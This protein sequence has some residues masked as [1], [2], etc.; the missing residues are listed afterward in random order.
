MANPY[1]F[2]ARALQR[3]KGQSAVATAAYQAGE[4]LRDQRTG[5]GH[6]YSKKKQGVMWSEIL[7]PSDSPGWVKDRGYLWNQA[8]KAEKRKDGQSARRIILALPKELTHELRREYSKQY[9]QEQFVNRGMVADFSIHLPEPGKN[10]DN[11]HLHLLTTMRD[12]GPDGFGSK[13]RGWNQKSLLEEWREQ[14]AVHTNRALTAAGFT[15]HWDHRTLEAQGVDRLPGVHLGPNVVEMEQKGLSTDRA[16]RALEIAKANHQ[17]TELQQIEK[18]IQNEHERPGESQ[19]ISENA[20]RNRNHAPAVT[21][22]KSENRQS[23]KTDRGHGQS[24]Q[25]PPTATPAVSKR[26]EQPARQ[27]SGPVSHPQG[28][29]DMLSV[30]EQQDF[31]RIR[32]EMAKRQAEEIVRRRQELSEE[33]K[34]RFEEMVRRVEATFNKRPDQLFWEDYFAVDCLSELRQ[35]KQ[36]VEQADWQKIEAKVMAGLLLDGAS[37]VD[38]AELLDEAGVST[39]AT[40]PDGKATGERTTLEYLKTLAS[41][42]PELKDAIEQAEERQKDEERERRSRPLSDAPETTGPQPDM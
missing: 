34:K 39:A 31:L 8:E 37:V 2:N 7:A 40:S 25:A 38:V 5:R 28:E 41:S 15:A 32:R 30:E 22:G 4:K 29:S 9:I 3:S 11:H 1:S 35:R 19:E 6:N 18:D 23:A 12:I 17:L 24:S 21:S 20:R 14:W 27:A 10:Q 13:N 36:T 16:D 26:S 33:Q 42:S